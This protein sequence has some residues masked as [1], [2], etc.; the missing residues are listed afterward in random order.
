MDLHC[1]NRRYGLTM[2]L[3]TLN[4]YSR[5]A[6]QVH[7]APCMHCWCAVARDSTTHKCHLW[8]TGRTVEFTPMPCKQ[9]TANGPSSATA[10]QTYSDATYSAQLT[11]PAVDPG[12]RPDSVPRLRAL[13]PKSANDWWCAWWWGYRYAADAEAAAWELGRCREAA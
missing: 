11:H 6:W 3:L 1:T 9:H 13:R 8:L 7:R 5:C 10:V 4:T 2:Q 12:R